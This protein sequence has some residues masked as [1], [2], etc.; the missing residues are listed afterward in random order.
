[1]S[2]FKSRQQKETLTGRKRAKATVFQD[3]ERRK[4]G[5]VVLPGAKKVAELAELLKGKIKGEEVICLWPM[6][7][8][9]LKTAKALVLIACEV[10]QF[11]E[12]SA[13]LEELAMDA[14]DGI[15]PLIDEMID[16]CQDT[17]LITPDDTPWLL[18]TERDA[19]TLTLLDAAVERMNK[20]ISTVFK[21]KRWIKSEERTDFL[22]ACCALF[23]LAEHLVHITTGEHI[24][25]DER[26]EFMLEEAVSKC[27]DQTLD[28]YGDVDCENEEEEEESGEEDDD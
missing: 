2:D 3:V 6:L 15:P 10:L 21:S 22:N 12:L 25:L 5:K 11:L 27:D 13:D 28:E 14:R 18:D 4:S 9:K 8:L 17:I 23:E 24:E 16:E 19:K 26:L 1:M 7:H 20:V